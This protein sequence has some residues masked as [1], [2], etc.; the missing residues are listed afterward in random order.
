RRPSFADVARGQRARGL[1]R[2]VGPQ[3]Y[4]AAVRALDAQRRGHAGFVQHLHEKHSRAA[5][6]QLRRRGP[7]LDAHA[8]LGVDAHHG[9]RVLVER[10][11]DLADAFFL[12]VHGQGVVDQLLIETRE[13][14][15]QIGERRLETTRL[16]RERLK[17]DRWLRHADDLLRTERCRAEDKDAEADGRVSC[18]RVSHTAPRG[19]AYHAQQAIRRLPEALAAPD[20]RA[21]ILA[22]HG[23]TIAPATARGLTMTRIWLLATVLGLCPRPVSAQSIDELVND[24][25]NPENV[26]TQSMGYDRKSY[27]PLKQINTSNISRLVPIWNASLMNDM[28]EL[29]A[30]TIYDGVMYAIN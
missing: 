6:D 3:E 21:R 1:R 11:L 18:T 4:V 27:S 30:P 10:S 29:A 28:G 12:L 23:Q 22:S 25:R 2:A 9:E 5:F 19:E 17:R 14:L 15:S 13:R 8:A 7:L 26:L 20:V 24:G 16:L